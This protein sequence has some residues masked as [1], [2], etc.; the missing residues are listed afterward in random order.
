MGQVER[1]DRMFSTGEWNGKPLQY[2]CLENSMNSM[3][4]QSDRI[5][6]E[7]LPRLVSAQY[8]TLDQYL[9]GTCKSKP[10]WDIAW[11]QTIIIVEMDTGEKE[12][13]KHTLLMGMWIGTT[14][15]ENSM[16]I[17]QKLIRQLLYD[18]VILVL[19]IY[20]KNKKILI[21]KYMCTF[22]FIRAGIMY[23]SQD[24]ETMWVLI[25]GWMDKDVEHTYNGILLKHKKDELLALVAT[26]MIVR[27][28]F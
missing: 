1:S 21:R 3:K 5:L 6:K 2:S 10:Q 7:E 26:W 16:E 12:I 4:K 19:G 13:L 20:L 23:N 14:T 15:M 24:M 9:L 25:C 22:L 18:P 17:S 11:R 27:T 8:T 28:L